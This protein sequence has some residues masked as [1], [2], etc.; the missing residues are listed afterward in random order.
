MSLGI[1]SHGVVQ[2]A[3]H[4][5]QSSAIKGLARFGFLSKGVVYGLLGVL[6][7][8]AAWGEGGGTT[9]GE[10]TLKFLG[11]GPFGTLL[12]GLIG[13]GLAGYA[14]WRL[15]EAVRDPRHVGTDGKGKF[16]R[17]G[18]AFSSLVNGALAATAFQLAFSGSSSGGGQQTWIAKAMSVPFGQF[19]VGVIGVGVVVSAV[20]QFRRAW[21]EKF[22]DDLETSRM[23]TKERS[24]TKKLGKVGIA[25]RAGVFVII[26]VAIT[27]AAINHSPGQA[28][29]V[30]E[31]L[32]D[33]GQSTWG[34]A[35]LTIVAGGFVAYAIYMLACMRFRKLVH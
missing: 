10:G 24:W 12:V 1:H 35:L 33:I 6:S 29:G 15:I 30:G 9:D 27:R 26:G 22:M 17:V 8:L 19:L 11:K 32:S 13:V 31:A 2:R 5:E 34:T 20:A 21:N 16:K 23:S 25:A 4:P 7:L 3:T 18:Y 28:K 14:L